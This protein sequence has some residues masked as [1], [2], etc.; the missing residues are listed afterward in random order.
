[1]IYRVEKRRSWEPLVGALFWRIIEYV[2]LGDEEGASAM[3][4]GSRSDQ[5]KIPDCSV[6][7]SVRRL[8]C[9]VPLAWVKYVT[10]FSGGEVISSRCAS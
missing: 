10:V 7:S 3:L 4:R 9:P 8:Y 1:M 5:F 2:S 6:G